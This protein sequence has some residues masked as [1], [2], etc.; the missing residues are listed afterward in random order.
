MR[1][2]LFIVQIN[3]KRIQ[4]IWAN[5]GLFRR[6][7]HLVH[8]REGLQNK[9]YSSSEVDWLKLLPI[10]WQLASYLEK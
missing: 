9:T 6:F 3:H 8:V 10:L 4:S 7:F 2:L 1:V 5:L